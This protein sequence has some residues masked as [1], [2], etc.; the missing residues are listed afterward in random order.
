MREMPRY[1]IGVAP[2]SFLFLFRVSCKSAGTE[3]PP[4]CTSVCTVGSLCLH[5]WIS[6]SRRKERGSSFLKFAPPLGYLHLQLII[7][8]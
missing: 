7:I 5:E 3:I 6:I 4:V 1:R 8:H 2:S